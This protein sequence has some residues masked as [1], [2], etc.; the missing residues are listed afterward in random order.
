MRVG[1]VA[2]GAESQCAPEAPIWRFGWPPSSPLGPKMQLLT[3]ALA[4]WCVGNLIAASPKQRLGCIAISGA[5]DAD[6]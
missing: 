3:H 6:R 5:P 4:W 1:S 2:A